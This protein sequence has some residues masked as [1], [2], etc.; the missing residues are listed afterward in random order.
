MKKSLYYY[1]FLF[2]LALRSSLAAT[3]DH[4][5]ASDTAPAALQTERDTAT[6]PATTWAAESS[7]ERQRSTG[8]AATSAEEHA[9]GADP[10]DSGGGGGG[11]HVDGRAVDSGERAG[12]DAGDE[13]GG[14]RAPDGRDSRVAELY[15]DLEDSVVFEDSEAGGGPNGETPAAAGGGRLLDEQQS[16]AENGASPL[17]PVAAAADDGS[18]EEYDAGTADGDAATAGSSPVVVQRFVKY[19]EYVGSS[20]YR[21]NLPGGNVTRPEDLFRFWDPTEW[22]ATSRVS[23]PC[24]DHMQ[25]YQVA[26]RNGKMWAFK[27]K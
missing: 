27:S 19:P 6:V 17:V 12:D 4:V 3:G 24:A 25:Q 8:P 21:R 5:V 2:A 13:D 23:A 26:L 20:S 7:A 16:P 10:A 22:T 15:E 11:G 9:A 1:C 18:T 14:Q